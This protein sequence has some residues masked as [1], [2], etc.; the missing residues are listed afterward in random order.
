MAMVLVLFASP[1]AYTVHYAHTAG[2]TSNRL[3]HP[4]I[5]SGTVALECALVYS[6]RVRVIATAYGH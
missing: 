5:W 4:V 3:V 2:H 1:G 6:R